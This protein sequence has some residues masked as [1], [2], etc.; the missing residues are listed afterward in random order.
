MNHLIVYAHPHE[1]S[2]NNAILDTAVNALKSKGHEVSVRDLN[3]L[4]FNPVLSP[5]DTAALREGNAPADIATEQE[6]LKKADVITFIY[7]IW[8]TGLPAILKGYVDRTFSY[9]FAY[10]YNAQ[11]GVDKLFTG[12]KGVIINTHGTPGEIYDSIGM[13]NS[14]KQTSDGGIFEF[15]GIEVLEHFL[16]GGVTTVATDKDR[17]NMLVQVQEKFSSL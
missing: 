6:Y 5:A 4:G 14:L 9:G 11:G 17:K 2:F 12:K 10:Q 7:P 16:F 3:K 15:C 1:G 8:W 13:S